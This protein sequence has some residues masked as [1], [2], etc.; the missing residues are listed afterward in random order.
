MSRF[1][2]LS[3][4]IVTSSS[5]TDEVLVPQTT[6]VVGSTSSSNPLIPFVSTDPKSIPQNIPAV[7]IKN[8][9]FTYGSA[10][11]YKPILHDIS[12]SLPKGSRTL[13]VGDNGAGKSTLL[14]ILAGRHL[15][16]ENTV[17]VLGSDTFFDT[18]LNLRRGYL[19]TDWG[20][21]TVAFTGHGC[22]INADVP[23]REM[24]QSLQEEYPQRRNELVQLLGVDLDWRMHMLSDGQRRRVQI[25][26]QLL[27]PVEI[28]LLDEITTDLDLITR[29]DF[30]SHL[31]LLTER[32]GTTIIYATHIFDGL[33]DWPTHLAYVN[34]GCL[35]KFGPITTFTD[36]Q[37][38]RHAKIVAP[39]L[40]TIEAWLRHAR[41]EKIKAGMKITEKAEY[42]SKD[43]LLGASGNGYLPGRFSQGYG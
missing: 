29:Q 42:E 15:C 27:R 21:R 30:L 35:A 3:T 17:T 2:R 31:Q 7:D 40:R 41:D 32:D 25:M 10:T 14:R 39:L 20:R 36:F 16:P 22:A 43:E 33:D 6:T 24:M 18:S 19:G 34:E 9:T 8:L 23:V 11:N 13:L 1:D 38:R 5:P 26:L 28:L 4:G 12:I 37:E